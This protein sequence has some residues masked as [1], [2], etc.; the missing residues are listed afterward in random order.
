MDRDQNGG[1]G[2]VGAGGSSQRIEANR[3]R[4][5]RSEDV[6]GG[7]QPG[8][9]RVGRSG[10]HDGVPRSAEQAQRAELHGERCGLLVDRGAGGGAPDAAR[11][12][13]AVAGIQEHDL[14]PVATGG[15]VLDTGAG[16]ERV[17]EVGLGHDDRPAGRYR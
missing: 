1:P 2:R 6:V 3:V 4:G 8:H 10:D 5:E 17:G 12:Q 7:D 11:V 13:T 9:G 14:V 16:I 15:R